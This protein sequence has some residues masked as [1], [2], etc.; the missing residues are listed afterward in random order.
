MAAPGYRI[1]E[2]TADLRVEFRARSLAELLALAGRVLFEL[3][4]D[5]PTPGPLCFERDLRLEAEEPD[6]L[7]RTWLAELLFLHET[8]HEVYGDCAV[9]FG[10]EGDLR[11][12]LRGRPSGE[13]A[14]RFAREI[15]AVTYHGLLLEQTPDGLRAE[16]IFDL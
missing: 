16:V 4:L 12:H 6:L 15:K 5:G 3:L 11:A 2:H 7:L 10:P 8:E 9:E 1:L 13:L 14:G